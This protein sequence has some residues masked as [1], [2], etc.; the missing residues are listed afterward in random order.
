MPNS[1]SSDHRSPSRWSR[2]TLDP[3]RDLG[4]RTRGVRPFDPGPEGRRA[5]EPAPG[6]LQ[7]RPQ[8]RGPRP[9]ESSAAAAAATATP[10]ERYADG[11]AGGSAATATAARAPGGCGRTQRRTPGR[12]RV[13]VAPLSRVR[14]TQG[15]EAT[16]GTSRGD[17]PVCSRATSRRCSGCTARTRASPDG[18]HAVTKKLCESPASAGHIVGPHTRIAA[19][20]YAGY[21]SAAE[22]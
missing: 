19:Q 17:R 2:P 20:A 4:M 18:A 5:R 8:Q 13:R 16:D 1:P 7:R 15:R 21:A 11:C 22:T 10:H 9:P 14:A 12:R 3:V 6:R